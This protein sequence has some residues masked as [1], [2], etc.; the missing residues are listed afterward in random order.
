MARGG[1]QQHK[2][3]A[4]PPS[5]PF[6]HLLRQQS[7]NEIPKKLRIADWVSSV[8]ASLSPDVSAVTKV[9][10]P[11][12][13]VESI[14][15]AIKAP[16]YKLRQTAQRRLK[17][18]NTATNLQNKTLKEPTQ[19]QLTRA[20]E[21][22]MSTRGTRRAKR[23]APVSPSVPSSTRSAVVNST[24]VADD[25]T[26]GYVHSLDAFGSDSMKIRS[27][28]SR[29]TMQ[30]TAR[31]KRRRL[32]Q[33]V[34]KISFRRPKSFPPYIIKLRKLLLQAAEIQIAVIP[35]LL[36]EDLEKEY[37]DELCD[38]LP[39]AIWDLDANLRQPKA[40]ALLLHVLELFE[41]ARDMHQGNND[42]VDWYS[43][44][45]KALSGVRAL[46]PNEDRFRDLKAGSFT[47][48]PISTVHLPIHQ[49][50]KKRIASVKVDLALYYDDEDDFLSSMLPNTYEKRP[51][52]LCPLETEEDDTLIAIPVEVK[53][54]AGVANQAEFQL[55]VCA[56]ALLEIR[57]KWTAA[58][59][60][61]VRADK[62]DYT[63]ALNPSVVVALSVYDHHWTFYILYREEANA[64]AGRE[65]CTGLAP[66]LEEPEDIT[67]AGGETSAIATGLTY[68]GGAQID[69]KKE[70]SAHA[71]CIV[72]GPFPAGHTATLLGTFQL[73]RFIGVLR[74]WVA[75]E[76][77]KTI[78]EGCREMKGGQ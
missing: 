69:I 50:T 23:K 24:V 43:V 39:E 34:P 53:T 63:C 11:T 42:E 74:K 35:A 20:H 41:T 54:Y 73:V 14:H 10:L 71:P 77:M 32:K 57:E 52:K 76:W 6:Q 51:S 29:H 26:T 55:S 9:P 56:N 60:A 45:K 8:A 28:P 49:P 62:D 4:R 36:R 31:V 16:R 66:I 13:R 15:Q 68:L 17:T 37:A 33:C 38:V 21:T 1:K 70:S 19:Q 46:E 5:Q 47:S 72:H 3:G 25:E 67:I 59:L 65:E 27:D 2:P 75:E 44:I 22:T 40:S 12:E 30:S 78:E 58:C 7:S 18:K 61:S 64:S 48:K